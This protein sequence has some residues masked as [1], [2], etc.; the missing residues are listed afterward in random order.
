MVATLVAMGFDVVVSRRALRVTGCNLEH[1][2]EVVMMGGVEA[3]EYNNS[4][5][6]NGSGWDIQA[7]GSGFDGMD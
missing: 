4:G 7:V 6:G 2:A 1:A 5:S 3:T